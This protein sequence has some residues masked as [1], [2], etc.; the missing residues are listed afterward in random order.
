MKFIQQIGK[1]YVQDPAF[2]I[3]GNLY[4]LVVTRA[5]ISKEHHAPLALCA[6]NARL[7]LEESAVLCARHS[8]Y[9]RCV[10]ENGDLLFA[11][12]GRWQKRLST[13]E[14]YELVAF[15]EETTKN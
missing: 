3:D 12:N 4:E 13:K 15:L 11:V 7:F 2:D 10:A 5:V 9:A 6:R 8:N 14:S 1:G